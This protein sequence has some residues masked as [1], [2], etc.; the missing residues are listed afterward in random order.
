[1]DILL[2]HYAAAPVVGG[3][4]NVITHHARLMVDAGHTVR[5]AAGRGAQFDPRVPFIRLPLTD[6]R[7]AEILSVKAG[8]DA[9]R[10]PPEF[11]LLVK[12][13]V[14][15]LK[16]VTAGVEA[17]IAHNVCSLAKNLPLTA[18]L[19]VLAD[20][21]SLPPLVLWHHDLAWTTPR[22]RDE[23]H[24]G[25]PWDLLR[26]DWPGAVQ[27]T[28]SEQRRGELT[29]LLQVA[30]ERIN[31][32][33][34]G[35]DP[36]ELLKLEGQTSKLIE[37]CR[38]QEARPVLLL[39]ARITPRKNI[40]YA[41][42]LLRALRSSAFPQA[43]LVVTG[44]PGA[45][46]PANARYLESLLA[47]RQ[48]LGLEEAAHFLG[49]RS[50]EGLPAAVV[51]DLYRYA[52]ALFL[53]SAEEGFG[54][55]ILE[56]G[57]A[58][59]PV[60]CADLPALREIGGDEVA[61]FSPQDS[62][63]ETAALI[64]R[65]LSDD[66]VFRLRHAV[67]SRYTWQQLYREK[68][69]PLLAQLAG[70][71]PVPAPRPT[72]ASSRVERWFAG[73]TYRASQFDDLERLVALKEEQRLTISL[74][75]PTLNVVETLPNILCKV[76]EF[77]IDR[78]RLLDE[79]V[80]ID[81]GSVDGTC[82]AAESKGVPVHAHQEILPQYGRR[83]G[84]GEAIWKS[85]Y[86]T[87]GDLICWIDTDIY[88]FSPHFV[89]GLIGPL[90]TDPD[91]LYVKGFYRRPLLVDSQVIKSGGGRV[92]ELT[93]RPLLNM[94]YPELAGLVQ[95]LSG[96]YCGRRK[97]LEQLSFY[98]GYG[99]E[100]GLLIEFLEKFGLDSIAQV[101]L[102]ERVHRNK[103]LESLAV[104]AYAILQV[105]QSRLELR[106]G[107]RL[108]EQLNKTIWLVHNEPGNLYLY[109]QEVEENIRPAMIGIPEYLALFAKEQE[110][111]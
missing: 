49:L 98:S 34:N 85:L 35:V 61:Y 100:T 39:P 82:G 75:L 66:G 7:H 13:L 103:P 36:G 26:T 67:R 21:G 102:Y 59:L 62:P 19:K 27:V 99:V 71:K 53:P 55:P 15:A 95:P 79:I 77:L 60:F 12:R 76:K 89:Y 56:A 22:Y 1:M 64:A 4:E 52:D 104:M 97:A 93:A 28:V 37:S 74:A 86:V 80:V 5:V 47:L 105:L 43:A 51:S 92:T 90:L 110:G 41:L 81:S 101:D 3:V 44:P 16:A 24:P 23:L 25:Y 9:G 42:R 50:D 33:P 11:D 8:L 87:R 58:G 109:D 2:L 17:L 84:K 45:H 72:P 70:D 14:E 48:A 18:A 32:I 63:A 91:I 54:L 69:A 30:P 78:F 57:L 73:H 108:P 10:V 40:E 31:V 83:V 96:E 106:Y 68:I 65:R 46:N 94:F 29:A 111:I 107:Q 20:A 6:S 38:L 88:N